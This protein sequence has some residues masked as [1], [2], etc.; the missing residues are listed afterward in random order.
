[1]PDD[2]P[3]HPYEVSMEIVHL[4]SHAAVTRDPWQEPKALLALAVRHGRD[5]LRAPHPGA[6][7]YGNR[8]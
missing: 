6:S 8:R 7:A 5:C 2:T 1:M 3:A 4:A